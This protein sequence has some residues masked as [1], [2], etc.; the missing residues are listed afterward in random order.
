[1]QNKLILTLL[2]AAELV[3]CVSMKNNKAMDLK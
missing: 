1:M 3:C 2:D